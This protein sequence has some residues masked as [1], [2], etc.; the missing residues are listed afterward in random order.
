MIICEQVINM[1][2]KSIEDV[3]N[4]SEKLLLYIYKNEP[5]D[6]ISSLVNES[7]LTEDEIKIN[8]LIYWI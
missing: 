5:L 8:K 6:D 1:S 2:E 3:F 4:L 7:K